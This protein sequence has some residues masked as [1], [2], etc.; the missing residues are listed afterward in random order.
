MLWCILLGCQDF[1]FLPTNGI[2]I[3]PL[4]VKLLAGEQKA[5]FLWIDPLTCWSP[6]PLLLRPHRRR[7]SSENGL[8]VPW[9]RYLRTTLFQL[10][11][12]PRRLGPRVPLLGQPGDLSLPGGVYQRANPAPYSYRD[13]GWVKGTVYTLAEAQVDST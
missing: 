7:K 4:K 13:H 1:N 8:T 10:F 3:K 5:T 9:P 12:H 6:L 11:G 2:S